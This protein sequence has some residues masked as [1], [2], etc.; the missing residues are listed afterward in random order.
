MTKD[1]LHQI[2]FE[3]DTP[4][5][6]AFDIALLIAILLS[7]LGP[8]RPMLINYGVDNYIIIPNKEGLLNITALLF[9]LLFLEGFVQFFY[10]YI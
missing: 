2:I 3:A 10:I 7:V 9:I 5:G 8:V 6:K 4:K 1:R